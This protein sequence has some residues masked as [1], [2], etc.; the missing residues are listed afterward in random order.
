[1]DGTAFAN[2]SRPERLEDSIGLH[3]DS[4]EP[5]GVFRIVCVVRLVLVEAHGIDDLIGSW[6]DGDRDV[7]SAQLLHETRVEH[8]HRLRLQGE[9]AAATVARLD[10]QPMIDEVEIDLED[11]GT[12]R[13][14]RR[15]EPAGR[16]I[17]GNVP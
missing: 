15:R 8:S 3:E 16:H 4:P 9:R 13:D 11:A 2:E 6:M 7:E 17:Q 12:V 14:R 10:H 1:M 5:I